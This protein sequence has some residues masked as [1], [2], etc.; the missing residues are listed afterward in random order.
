MSDKDYKY[1]ISDP[2]ASLL[3]TSGA[4]V[5][6]L[7]PAGVA[8]ARSRSSAAC[9]AMARVGAARDARRLR[10]SRRR[11]RP[12]L[13][14]PTTYILFSEEVSERS[15]S[16]TKKR[17]PRRVISDVACVEDKCFEEASR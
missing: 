6:S 9:G 11:F 10:A 13:I 12:S 15:D 16:L 3:A 8:P 7:G 2:S 17:T 5:G 1:T 4:L 14:N